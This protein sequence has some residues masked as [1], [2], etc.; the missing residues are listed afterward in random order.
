MVGITTGSLF[1]SS[2]V[3]DDV[4]FV[5]FQCRTVEVFQALQ[6]AHRVVH[7]GNE[8]AEVVFYN[9]VEVDSPGSERKMVLRE[10]KRMCDVS[11]QVHAVTMIICGS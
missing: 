2:E 8:V 1:C 11:I 6:I 9:P 4:V 5:G 7:E 3:A 10:T